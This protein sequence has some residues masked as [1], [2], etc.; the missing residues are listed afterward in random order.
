[1]AYHNRVSLEFDLT[2]FGSLP[3]YSD[4]PAGSVI[5]QSQFLTKKLL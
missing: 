2:H 3:L 5:T 4:L 1:L